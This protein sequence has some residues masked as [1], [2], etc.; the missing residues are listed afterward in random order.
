MPTKLDTNTQPNTSRQTS[1]FKRVMLR[2]KEFWQVN[3][4][5]NLRLPL[6][7]I[8]FGLLAGGVFVLSI[9]KNPLAVYLAIWKSVFGS[10]KNFLDVVG[11]ATP[12]VFTGLSI[13]F[14]FRTGMFNIGAEGQ[15][16]MGLLAAGIAGIKLAFLP[17]PLLILVCLLAGALAGGI[18]AGIPG[19]LKAKRGVHEVINTIMMNYIALY[20][21]NTLILSDWL[22][23]PGFQATHKVAAKALIPRFLGTTA[24]WGILLAAAAV[25]VV[26]FLLW[27]TKLGYEIR[28]T[29]YNPD[30]AEYAGINVSNRLLIALVTSGI[31]AGLGGAVQTLGVKERVFQLFGFTGVGLDGIAVALIGRNH[32]VGVVLAALLYGTLYRSSAI[33]QLATG[34]P[35]QVIG[36]MQACIIFFVA[37]EEIIKLILEQLS[38]RRSVA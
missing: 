11:Q 30:A 18:W 5:S 17:G 37:A 24:N 38:K 21:T 12:L 7:A 27:R 35:K 34:V 29:G 31:L 16:T 23:A 32:P 25:V 8:A 19:W 3:W 15:Y 14:A 26:Y 2:L 10:P 28:A 22:K 13:A 1:R 4:Q 36:I 33:I 9:G 6:T 20:L